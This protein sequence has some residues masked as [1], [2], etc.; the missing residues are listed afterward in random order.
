MLIPKIV[1]TIAEAAVILMLAI[2][3]LKAPWLKRM[4]IEGA[5]KL[6]L[7][8]NISFAYK[9]ALGYIT[10]I[11]FPDVKTTDYFGFGYLLATLMAVKVHDKAILMRLTRATLQTSLTAV[12]VAS[13][14]GFTL[15]LLPITNRK[16]LFSPPRQTSPI[17]LKA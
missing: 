16:R 9:I 3:L 8:F 1:A 7:F 11:W 6:I 12:L 15:T 13:V 17:T 10:L 14:I 5:R 4:T 2:L